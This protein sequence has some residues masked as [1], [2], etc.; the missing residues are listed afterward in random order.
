MFLT[1]IYTLNSKTCSFQVG[2]D[3]I[4]QKNVEEDRLTLEYLEFD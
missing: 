1:Y 3:I 4:M 2:S